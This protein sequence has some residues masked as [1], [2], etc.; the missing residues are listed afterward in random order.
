MTLAVRLSPEYHKKYMRP[1]RSL[2]LCERT[3]CKAL[4]DQCSTLALPEPLESDAASSC[5]D[6][7]SITIACMLP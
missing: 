1:L 4:T 5:L 7:L 2:R 3:S 6:F